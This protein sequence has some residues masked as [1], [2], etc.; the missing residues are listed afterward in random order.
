MKVS[1]QLLLTLSRDYESNDS[2][3]KSFNA[4]QDNALALPQREFPNFAG[5]VQGKKVLDFGCGEGRQALALV[6]KMNCSVVGIDNNCSML[7][8][9]RHLAKSNNIPSERLLFTNM[10]TRDM[11][12]AFDIVLT[13][14]S[15]EHFMDPITILSE[16]KSLLKPRGKLFI[17]F[18]PPWYAPYGS[19]MQFFC[20]V[21]WLNIL[22]S[23]RTVM[24]VRSNFRDD[25][26]THYEEVESG[27]NKMTIARFE[28]IVARARMKIEYKKYSCTSGIN[29]LGKLPYLRE[30]FINHVSVILAKK[31]PRDI[32]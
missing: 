30:L 31:A 26:A 16:M 27:L 12:G 13:Q 29:V 9:A 4:A 6:N 14:N 11:Q 20:K 18:G 25:G 17:T 15:M 21:P 10:I 28:Q 22:F 1:E 8:K 24:N 2:Y 19:H 5:S 7:K 23:E 32:G 3:F